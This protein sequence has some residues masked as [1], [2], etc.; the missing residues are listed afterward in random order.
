MSLAETISRKCF[1]FVHQNHLVY[2][3]CWED[4]RLDRQALQLGS[5]DHVLVIT[6]AGGNALDYLLDA[7]ARVSAVDLNPRQ[8]ALLELKVAGIRALDFTT[9]FELFGLGKLDVARD[10]RVRLIAVDA[11]AE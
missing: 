7:P 3:T 8:N 1:E 9:F 5:D 6:S 4:P 2:N 11:D 10:E